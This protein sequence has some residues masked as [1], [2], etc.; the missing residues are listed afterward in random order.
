MYTTC[1]NFWHVAYKTKH[2]PFSLDI[3]FQFKA[4][5][6]NSRNNTALRETPST[7]ARLAQ[8]RGNVVWMVWKTPRSAAVPL[9][10]TAVQHSSLLWRLNQESHVPLTFQQVCFIFALGT[11]FR[12][13]NHICMWH[14]VWPSPLNHMLCL[15]VV[16]LNICQTVATFE[17]GVLE[18]SVESTMWN[19]LDYSGFSVLFLCCTCICVAGL[20]NSLT[21]QLY[22]LHSDQTSVPDSDLLFQ[23]SLTNTDSQGSHDLRFMIYTH[24]TTRYF[25]REIRTFS[26]HVF[27][28]RTRYFNT[29]MT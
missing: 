9:G 22:R 13:K 17:E 7:H 24:E 20:H 10:P 21:W 26:G 23:N 16:P 12:G 14:V 8:H 11:G 25:W 5:I 2:M 3:I 4:E 29:N 6:N 1:W 15:L 18:K 19:V 27:G 28:D